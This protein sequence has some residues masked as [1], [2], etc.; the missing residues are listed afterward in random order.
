MVT[1]GVQSNKKTPGTKDHKSGSG[2]VSSGKRKANSAEELEDEDENV[3]Q[4]TPTNESKKKL[5]LLQPIPF[6]SP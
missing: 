4:Q 6:Q 5:S 3:V 2:V 1:F